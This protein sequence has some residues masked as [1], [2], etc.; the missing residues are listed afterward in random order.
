MARFGEEQGGFGDKIRRSEEETKRLNRAALSRFDEKL[1]RLEGEE[2]DVMTGLRAGVGRAAS[3]TFGRKSGRGRSGG[4]L[5]GQSQIEMD[6]RRQAG[7]ARRE[8]AGEKEQTQFDRLAL[9][10]SMMKT[11]AQLQQE[12]KDHTSGN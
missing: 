11:P 4:M 8:F 3:Q 10:K 9:E 2:Q 7:E 1:G 5:R 6:L 12:A